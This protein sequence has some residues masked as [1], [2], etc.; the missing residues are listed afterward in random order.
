MQKIAKKEVFGHFL[1]LGSSDEPDIEC[2]ESAKCFSTF[3]YGKRS[4]MIN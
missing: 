1:E 3:V 4:C 2:Y